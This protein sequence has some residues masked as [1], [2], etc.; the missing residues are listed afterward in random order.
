MINNNNISDSKPLEQLAKKTAFVLTVCSGKGGVGKSVIVSNLAKCIS[1]TQKVLIWDAVKMFPNQ[2]LLFAVEPPVR[3]SD[4]YSGS[5]NLEKAIFQIDNNLFLLAD[6]PAMPLADSSDEE[7]II[8]VFEELV[9]NFDFDLIIFDTPAGVSNELVQCCIV[10]DLISIVVNDEPTSLLDA[11]GL[12]KILS[13]YIPLKKLNLLINNA[14]DNEDAEEISKKLNLVT[15]KFLKRKFNLL[16]FIPY[17]RAVRQSI[18]H[19]EL[20][21]IGEPK[22]EVSIS[23]NNISEKISEIVKAKEESQLNLQNN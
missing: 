11:Y 23:V 9:N 10:S 8:S 22:S 20:F 14:I 12:I 1:K 16:G 13:N 3:L 2:H 15:E 18:L 7:N 17:D 4:V 21:V 5:I 19:Q 6:T